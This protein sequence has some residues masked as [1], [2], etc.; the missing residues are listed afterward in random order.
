MRRRQRS[1]VALLQPLLQSRVLCNLNPYWFRPVDLIE[2]QA[3]TL[4]IGIGRLVARIFN[5]RGRAAKGLRE[6]GRR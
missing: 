4:D 1:L 3:R 6:Y 2:I 5:V